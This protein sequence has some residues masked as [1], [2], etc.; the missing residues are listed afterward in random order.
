MN[1]VRSTLQKYL[2]HVGEYNKCLD[3][4]ET[5]NTNMKQSLQEVSQ[6]IQDRTPHNFPDYVMVNSDTCLQLNWS[7]GVLKTMTPV[8]NNVLIEGKVLRL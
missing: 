4:L 6:A 3:K 7:E 8:E 5:A 2:N 1:E